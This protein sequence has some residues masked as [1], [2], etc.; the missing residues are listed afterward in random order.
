MPEP[1]K[2]L[3]K[4]EGISTITAC[5]IYAETKGKLTSKEQFA[6]YCGVAPVD[7]SSGQTTRMRNNKG[8]NRVL[9]SIFYSLSIAQKRYNKKAK[10]YYEKKLSEGK[11]PRHA[12]KCLARQLTNIV[13]KMLKDATEKRKP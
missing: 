6:S 10:A 13:F 12:R 1:A 11:S 8:G 5:T 2:A 3:T 9:N 4:M 7:C